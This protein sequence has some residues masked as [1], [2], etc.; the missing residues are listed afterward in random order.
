MRGLISNI[1]LIFF[2]LI[3]CSS[4]SDTEFSACFDYVFDQD[5]NHVLFTNDT[6]GDYYA[7]SWDFG[8]GEEKFSTNKSESFTIYYPESGD[9]SVSLKALT[10]GGDESEM[11]KTIRITND[12]LKLSFSIKEDELNPNKIIINNTSRGEYDSFKW[13]YRN[14]EIENKD[15]IVA[16]FP[17]AGDYTVELQVLKDN[18]VVSKTESLSIAND[19][20]D[21]LNN[22]SLIWSDEFD[23]ESVNRDDWTFETGDHGW[24]NQELQNY[25]DG[26]NA[27]V[28]DGT[29]KIVAKKI[30]D[31]KAV[32]SYTSTRLISKKQFTYGRMEARMKLPRGTGVWPAFWML[33]SN[34][35]T[36]G[37][38]SCG[39]VDI[40]EY[41]GYNPNY[42]HSAI[43][44]LSSYGNTENGNK[45]KL[46]TAEEEFH[47]YG[48]IWTEG[49]MRFYVDDY[50]NVTYIYSPGNKNDENWPFNKSMFFILNLAVG[51]SWGGSQGVD[52]SI[53]PQTLEIDYVRVFQEI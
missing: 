37:W 23:D 7:L 3:S 48:L 4:N 22:M 50:E 20:Q 41:V 29:L 11:K 8:N 10:Y 39:E 1:F 5:E 17:M 18:N 36:V 30:N 38:P 27:I 33:G 15:E 6:K 40:L 49:E 35:S 43:H 52:N 47:I 32:G 19:D 12:D 53:F 25:T 45:S 16:Y 9:Y 46:E 42:V 31:N 24:G 28:S 51:G 2:V 34:I 26:D 44:T 21:Y 14:K 13:I